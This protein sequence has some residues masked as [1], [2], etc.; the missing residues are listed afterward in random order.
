MTAMV[1]EINL[2]KAARSE[3][4]Q[5]KRRVVALEADNDHLRQLNEHLQLRCHFSAPALRT[6]RRRAALHYTREYPT[7]LLG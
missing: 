7:E 6:L 1:H 5:L 3:G 2:L 4:E